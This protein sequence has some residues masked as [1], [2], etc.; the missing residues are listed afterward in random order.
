MQGARTYPALTGLFRE[1]GV[2][3]GVLIPPPDVR[4]T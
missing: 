3:M 2:V 4:H 1:T